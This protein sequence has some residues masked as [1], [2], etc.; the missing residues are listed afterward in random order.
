MHARN[1]CMHSCIY[2]RTGFNFGD[3][4]KDGAAEQVDN[5]KLEAWEAAHAKEIVEKVGRPCIHT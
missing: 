5:S 2:C 3:D 4:A 1:K